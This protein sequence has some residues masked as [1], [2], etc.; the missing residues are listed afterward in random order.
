MPASLAYPASAAS[1]SGVNWA[2]S[3]ALIS[4]SGTAAGT[5][6]SSRTR[7]QCISTQECQSKLP[8]KTGVRSRGWCGNSPG[9]VISAET[10]VG[11]SR[12][13]FSSASRA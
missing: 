5:V 9:L 2:S 10:S 1:P 4:A 13:M 7:T 11:Y 3:A 8:K 6:L 12:A